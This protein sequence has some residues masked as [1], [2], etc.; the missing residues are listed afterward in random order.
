MN[1]S[2]QPESASQ[3]PPAEA[4]PAV[5]AARRQAILRGLGQGGAAL[6]ALSPVA[7]HAT[8]AF[9]V[10]NPELTPAGFGYCTVSGFQ[11]A[12]ISGSPE[13]VQCG[14]FE[15]KDFVA[16]LVDLDYDN[17]VSTYAPSATGT[18]NQKLATA[19]NA[20]YGA[21][22]AL[23]GPNIR[24]T[25]RKNPP[26]KLVITY[27]AVKAVIVPVPLTTRKGTEYRPTTAFPAAVNATATFQSIFPSSS[28]TR[29]LL[30]VLQDGVD[31]SSPASA[32]CYVLAAWLS[33]GMGGAVLPPSVD[34]TYINAQY[35]ASGYDASTNL[36]KFFRQ[37][38]I[39]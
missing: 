35:T 36:Y 31:S 13:A 7:G 29:T 39:G 33:V 4:E 23:T 37:L 12:A 28:D 30:E 15:P 16:P 21:G 8:R 38:C 26:I 18:A 20:Y 24:D 9:K 3:R 5:V 22:V 25:L 17:L 27:P 1:N 19:L 6:V 14:A 11:S 10:P 2:S 34:R 32:N